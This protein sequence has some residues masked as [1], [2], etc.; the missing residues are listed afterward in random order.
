MAARRLDQHKTIKSKII[1]KH[2][3][4]ECW[5]HF[6]PAD[7]RRVKQTSKQ[8]Y[9]YQVAQRNAPPVLAVKAHL[10]SLCRIALVISTCVLG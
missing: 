9:L 1:I 8:N 2:K 7:E 10:V 3:S 5:G 6:T 4:I